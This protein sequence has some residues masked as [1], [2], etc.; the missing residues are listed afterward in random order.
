MIELIFV[1]V[2][3]GILAVVAIPKFSQ[4]R[5]NASGSMCTHEVNQLIHEIGNSYMKEG[6]NKFL[7]LGIAKISNVSVNMISNGNGIV[8]TADTT[9]DTTGVTYSCEGEGLLYLVGG[10]DTQT[11]DYLLKI[12]D[13]TPT[14]PVA[15]KAAKQLRS[16]HGIAVGGTRTF[17]L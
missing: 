8:N 9:V 5:D 4:N 6:H 2:I 3:I 16:L 10:L 12:T 11:H 15:L 14:H 1:I 13:L 17:T 7:D